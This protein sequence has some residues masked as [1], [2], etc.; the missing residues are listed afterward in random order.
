MTSITA[1]EF[2]AELRQVKTMA[3]GSANVTFNLPEYC[4]PQAQVMLMWINNAVRV[5]VDSNPDSRKTD[6]DTRRKR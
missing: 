4:L 2:E 1:V 6:D 5:L 3:D